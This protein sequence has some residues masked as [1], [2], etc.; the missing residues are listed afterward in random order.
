MKTSTGF[1]AS[2]Y[3]GCGNDFLLLDNRQNELPALT[4][5]II[6]KLCQSSGV[7]GLILVCSS[8]KADLAMRFYNLDGSEAEM[9]GNGVRCLMQYVRQKLSYP[10]NR[11]LLETQK[12]D[13]AIF[14]DGLDVIVNI[15]SVVELGFNI[16]LAHEDSTYKLH[17]FNSSVPHV[18]IF[19][20]DIDAIDVQKLGSYFRNHPHFKPAG[21]NVNFVS[22]TTSGGHIRT[23]ERGVEGETLACGTGV[24]ASAYAM[25]KLFGYS[26]PISLQVRS[27]DWLSVLFDKT[28]S[29]SLKG[30]AIWIR[31]AIVEF[32]SDSSDCSIY[33]SN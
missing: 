23:F 26:T 33:F 28:D 2:H 8:T 24:L 10:R 3:S 19:V 13:I 25:H 6:Q 5:G 18:V 17:H 21:T 31:D 15:G 22:L 27:A 4:T 20:E 29:I 32:D 11:L 7:D 16:E 30:P 1:A 12:R 14:S 9:C